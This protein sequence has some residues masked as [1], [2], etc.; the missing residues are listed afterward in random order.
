MDI[1]YTKSTKRE[2]MWVGEG[3]GEGGGGWFLPKP[4]GHG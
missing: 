3:G 4:D 1:H 2:K